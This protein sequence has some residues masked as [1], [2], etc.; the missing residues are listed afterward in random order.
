[1]VPFRD[2]LDSAPKMGDK[3]TYQM[4]PTNRKEAIL[5]AN[6]DF[7]EGADFLMVKPAMPYLDIISDLKTNFNLPIVAYQVSGEYSM[8]KGAIANGWLSPQ[9][10]IIESLY[11]IKRAGAD[12]IIT[13]FAKEYA[14]FKI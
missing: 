5:E 14:S 8:I 12:I 3:K 10:P 11:S 9:Q 4:S 2:A 7:M 1:M 6:L 13:Y